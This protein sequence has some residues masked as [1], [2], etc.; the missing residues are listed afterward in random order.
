MEKMILTQSE[1]KI[2]AFTRMWNKSCN[3]ALPTIINN[4]L[5]MLMYRIESI[6]KM[7]PS[8]FINPN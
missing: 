7:V 6:S 1:F 5:Y 2:N 8:E 3:T 4:N